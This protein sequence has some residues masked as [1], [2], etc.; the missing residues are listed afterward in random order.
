MLTRLF[1]GLPALFACLLMVGCKDA[2]DHVMDDQLSWME[3]IAV[4]MKGVADEEMPPDQATQAIKE[5]VIQGDEIRERKRELSSELTS[6]RAE[7]LIEDYNLPVTEK[8]G[9]IMHA[10]NRT[11]AS[12]RL[13]RELQDE[14]QRLKLVE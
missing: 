12:G 5:L 3:E 1:F 13:T 14:F 6:T 4:V 2:H 10:M 8:L 7:K 11:R 9:D